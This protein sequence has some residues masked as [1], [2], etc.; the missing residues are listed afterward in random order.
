MHEH[1]SENCIMKLNGFVPP[2]NHIEIIQLLKNLQIKFE[3]DA[4]LKKLNSTKQ[5][6]IATFF[7]QSLFKYEYLTGI[8]YVIH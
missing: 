5:T 7:F 6:M 2:T 4:L 8:L 1:K 3:N